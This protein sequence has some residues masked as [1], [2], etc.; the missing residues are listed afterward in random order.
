[1]VKR[2][3][4]IGLGIAAGGLAV[5]GAA[6]AF[7]YDGAMRRARA[8][9]DPSL[10]TVIPTR[11]GSL[12]Y[13]ESGQG[14]PLLMI[15]GTGGGF[16]QGLLF[17]RRP[18]AKGYR[19]ISPSRFGYLRSSFP[20]DP[21]SANQADVLVELLDKLGLDKVAVAGGSG[22]PFRQLSLPSGTLIGA[23]RSCRSCPRPMP[24]IVMRSRQ[25]IHRPGS[26]LRQ[27]Y[28]APTSCS[29]QRSA[30]YRTRWWAR[31]WQPIRPYSRP[32]M[33]TSRH[34]RSKYSGRSSR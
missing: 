22:G 28:F 8:A 30:S 23:Q 12:E 7:S 19:V 33:R 15:H 10:S 26:T 2:R 34:G 27:H 1:M 14:S 16:D 5:G 6:T 31:F 13:A 29:G 4:L 3:T 24:R 32:S 17:A 25:T 18:V 20:E 11:L 21:S 9:T